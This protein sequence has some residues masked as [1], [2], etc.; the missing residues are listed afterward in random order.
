[1]PYIPLPEKQIHGDID[2]LIQLKQ[3][4]SPINLLQHIKVEKY[5]LNNNQTINSVYKNKQVDYY[6][7]KN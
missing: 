3:Q 2:F 5:I 7:V 1:M 4:F 6:F